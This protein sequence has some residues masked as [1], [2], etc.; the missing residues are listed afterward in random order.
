[1]YVIFIFKNCPV[2]EEKKYYIS[3]N[4]YQG[5]YVEKHKFVPL[6]INLN[7]YIYEK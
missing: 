1:M 4:L 6:M 2:D 5:K 7:K 3:N